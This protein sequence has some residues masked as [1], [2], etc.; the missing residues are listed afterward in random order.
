M[1]EDRVIAGQPCL[2][3]ARSPRAASEK[4]A[5]AS[6]LAAG[7]SGAR[8][9]ARLLGLPPSSVRNIFHGIPDLYPYRLQSCHELLAADAVQREAFAKVGFFQNRTESHLGL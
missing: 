4:E 3:K 2:R 5:L 8:E 7:T 9:A 6:E 1:L